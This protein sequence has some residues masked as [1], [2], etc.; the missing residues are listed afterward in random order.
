MD[1]WRNDANVEHMEEDLQMKGNIIMLTRIGIYTLSSDNE[2][3]IVITSTEL[4]N[5]GA[6]AVSSFAQ[7]DAETIILV[8]N[9]AHCLHKL[10][11]SPQPS[12]VSVLAGVCNDQYP[13]TKDGTFRTARFKRPNII[14][15]GLSNDYYL[16]ETGNAD[17]IVRKVKVDDETVSDGTV[18]NIFEG[19]QSQVKWENPYAMTFIQETNLLFVSTTRNLFSIDVSSQPVN[20]TGLTAGQRGNQ[21]GLLSKSKFTSS[22]ALATVNKELLLAAPTFTEGNVLRVIN[23]RN[24]FVFTLAL[25]Y[26]NAIKSVLTIAHQNKVYVGGENGVSILS[27]KYSMQP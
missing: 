15:K 24:E 19:T 20:V 27:C 7:H 10:V 8:D 1:Y 5:Q 6:L 17:G 2:S 21:D 14:A 22:N 16:S 23:L 3:N 26:S 12:S 25:N 9:S 18:T 13:V 11:R 4:N